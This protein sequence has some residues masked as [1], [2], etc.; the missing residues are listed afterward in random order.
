MVGQEGFVIK[1]VGEGLHHYPLKY[2]ADH[3]QEGD[4]L[5]VGSV[6]FG[7]PLV[8]GT[9][10]A[11]FHMEGHVFSQTQAVNTS[12][13]GPASSLEQWC[14]TCGFASL[15]LDAFSGVYCS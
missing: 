9:T 3:R 15:G 4:R 6:S 10:R 2:F 1:V 11:S 12:V 14:S 5:I 7:F 13:R 8:Y